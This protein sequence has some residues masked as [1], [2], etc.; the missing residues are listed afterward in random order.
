MDQGKP[1]LGPLNICQSLGN[2]KVFNKSFA[3]YLKR[4]GKKDLYNLLGIQAKKRLIQIGY[5]GNK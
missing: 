5:G 2:A 3:F 4:R 1:D